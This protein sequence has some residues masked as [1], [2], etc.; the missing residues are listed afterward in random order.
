[1]YYKHYK[2]DNTLMFL[3]CTNVHVDEIFNVNL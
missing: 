1:M 3:L 2:Y